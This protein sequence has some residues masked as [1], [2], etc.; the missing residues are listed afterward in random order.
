MASTLSP[1]QIDIIN[2]TRDACRGQTTIS[3][4]QNITSTEREVNDSSPVSRQ[5][6]FAPKDENNISQILYNAIQALGTGNEKVEQVSLTDVEIRWSGAPGASGEE[7]STDPAAS[8]RE[9]YESVSRGVKHPLTI[10]Y[11]IGGGFYMNVPS[12]YHSTTRKLAELTGGRCISFRYRLSPKNTFPAALLDAFFTYLSLLRPSPGNFH[13]PVP[14]SSIVFA[15]DS[16]GANIA[17]ALIQL[18]L[19]ANN[20]GDKVVFNGI[21]DTIPLPAGVALLSAGLDMTYALGLKENVKYDIFHG[22]WSFQLPNFPACS[23]WP[24]NPPRSHIY[25]DKSIMC[26]PLVSPCVAATWKG[27]PPMW[28]ACGQEVMA[29]SVRMAAQVIAQHGGQVVYEEY[30][31]MPHDFAIMSEN[32]PWALTGEWP[33]SVRCMDRWAKA[34][35][36]FFERREVESKAVFVRTSGVEDGMELE[37]LSST[38]LRQSKEKMLER[39]GSWKDWTGT[40]E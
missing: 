18:I 34:C 20:R 3:Q 37:S 21:L 19:S 35:L 16:A 6:L 17:S 31:E 30:E 2:K 40:S 24:S 26:H 13:E 22:E 29:G 10:M 33:Q 14:A 32:W 38:D 8:E 4:L 12:R 28:L 39:I 11:F 5:I 23:L 1:E 25:G 36:T 9:R 7:T 15:G 27:A